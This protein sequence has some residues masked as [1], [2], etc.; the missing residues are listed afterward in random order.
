MQLGYGF[1]DYITWYNN[2]RIHFSLRYL[3]S[4]EYRQNTLK[5][6]F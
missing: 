6:V 2:P 3:L 1:A 4:V 5:K